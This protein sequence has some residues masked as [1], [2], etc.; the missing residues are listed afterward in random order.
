VSTTKVSNHV[1]GLALNTEGYNLG[2]A[3]PFLCGNVGND[4]DYGS[5]IFIVHKKYPFLIII[6][7]DIKMESKKLNKKGGGRK[8]FIPPAEYYEKKF[9]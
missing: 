2:T 8:D 7:G 9:N 1:D 3:I 5:Q 4:T 6:C